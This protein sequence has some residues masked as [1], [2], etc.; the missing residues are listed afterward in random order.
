[1]GDDLERMLASSD[2]YAA[3]FDRGE[4]PAPPARR[5]V[6]VTCMDARVQPE[7]FLGLRLG[8]A[9]VLRNAGGRVTGD[10]LRSLVVSTNILGTREVLVIHHTDCGTANL[11]QDQ[12]ATVVTRQSGVDACNVDFV[13]I[14]DRTEALAEDVNRVVHCPWLPEGVRVSGYRFDVTSGA[15]EQE[16]P[17]VAAGRR[18][19]TA[20]E[21]R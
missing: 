12:I 15:L 6:V 20:A 9:H 19:D 17:P 4:Q 5:T 10:V 3:V 18:S 13:A 7:A 11:S 2:A 16:I 21:P 8:D 14:D 1:M